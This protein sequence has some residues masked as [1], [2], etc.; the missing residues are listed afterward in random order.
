[1]VAGTIAPRHEVS[2]LADRAQVSQPLVHRYFP[3]KAALR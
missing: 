2:A 1:M 3:T